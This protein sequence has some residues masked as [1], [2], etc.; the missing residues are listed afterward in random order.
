MGSPRRR[1]ERRL[2][3]SRLRHP[4]PN[5]KDG[6]A[7]PF[8]SVRRPGRPLVDA[9]GLA[10]DATDTAPTGSAEPIGGRTFARRFVRAGATARTET[11][12]APAEQWLCPEPGTCHDAPDSFRRIAPYALRHTARECSR[13][14]SVASVTGLRG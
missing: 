3:F 9:S 10:I 7:R 12:S 8:P 5:A 13:K 2:F 1:L 14:R 4:G 11:R 6:P